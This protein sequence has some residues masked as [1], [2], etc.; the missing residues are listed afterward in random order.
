MPALQSNGRRLSGRR[1]GSVRDVIR[2]SLKEV[3]MREG[4]ET[5]HQLS[6]ASGLAYETVRQI[7]MGRSTRVDLRTLDVLC[8]ILHVRPAQL[9][10][11]EDEPDSCGTGDRTGRGRD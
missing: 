7:W 2:W 5:P 6:V 3:S 4:Y 9:L 10:D 11:Y 8:H 1:S